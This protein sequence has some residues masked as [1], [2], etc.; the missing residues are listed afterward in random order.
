MNIRSAGRRADIVLRGAL[1]SAGAGGAGGGGGQDAAAARRR[2]M[3]GRRSTLR[4]TAAA[5]A[6]AG[7]SAPAVGAAGSAMHHIVGDGWSLEILVREL[8][9]LYAA[10]CGAKPRRPAAAADPVRRLRAVA[11]GMAAAARRCEA[12]ARLLAGGACRSA[13]GAGAAGRPR[14]SGGE[15]LSRRACGAADL[16]AALAG[17]LKALGRRH[18]ATLFMTLLAGFKVLL[19][20]LSGQRR[21]RGREPDRQP[22]AQPRRGAD[23]LLRQ[24]AGAAQPGRAD[25]PFRELLRQ[26][27][28]LRLGPM[29]TRTCRSRCW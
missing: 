5:A 20:R 4:G 26:V 19:P 13:G 14:A 8:R 6:A 21:H 7:G 24:H 28:G 11:A 10:A 9:A 16:D 27:R 17:R 12:P 2:R 1:R 3:R 23:R 18:G 22:P 15:E 25:P 29:R